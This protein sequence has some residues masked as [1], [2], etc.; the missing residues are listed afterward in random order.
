MSHPPASPAMS[1]NLLIPSQNKS[2]ISYIT[3]SDGNRKPSTRGL[4]DLHYV[5]ECVYSVWAQVRVPPHQTLVSPSLFLSQTSSQ[6]RLLIHKKKP[7][8]RQDVTP[9][10]SILHLLKEAQ[11]AIRPRGVRPVPSSARLSAC[12]S[13]YS[14]GL[15]RKT[16]EVGGVDRKSGSV[17]YRKSASFSWLAFEKRVKR[18]KEEEGWSMAVGRWLG[19]WLGALTRWPCSGADAGSSTW[20]ARQWLRGSWSAPAPPAPAA[21]W[22]L[23]DRWWSA[24][25]ILGE[26]SRTTQLWAGYHTHMYTLTSW[27]C[28]KWKSTNASKHDPCVDRVTVWPSPP[29]G[30]PGLTP[31]LVSLNCYLH[32]RPLRCQRW[33]FVRSLSVLAF[34]WELRPAVFI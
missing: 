13:V 12:G 2:N 15:W 29:C 30:H 9:H 27:W 33:I 24:G 18:S 20:R 26:H 19:G 6:R 3:Q 11:T 10:S 17:W 16:G 34:S 23:T 25:G 8:V 7:A 22:A 14:N 1:L 4:E 5:C 21:G 31:M 28:Y 32:K